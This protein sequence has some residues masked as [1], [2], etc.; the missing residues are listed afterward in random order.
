[1]LATF[2]FVVFDGNFLF[3]SFLLHLLIGI[4]LE[5]LSLLSHF[6]LYSIN[7]VIFIIIDSKY[8]MHNKCT[9]MIYNKCIYF[10]LWIVV[11]TQC[12]SDSLAQTAPA[13]APGAR[14]S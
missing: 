10:I 11:I 3:P 7:K 5:D 2:I 6:F 9:D 13:T 1:M 14:F 4:L 12:Y 8:I